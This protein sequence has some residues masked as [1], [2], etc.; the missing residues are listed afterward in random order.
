MKKQWNPPF[1]AH[2]LIVP[3]ITVAKNYGAM[4]G[5]VIAEDVFPTQFIDAGDTVKFGNTTFSVLYT[6]GHAR[7]HLSFYEAER[8][9][10]FSGDVLFDSGV[11]RWDFPGGDFDILMQSIFNELLTLP[12]ETTVYCGHGNE[13]TIGREKRL[14]PYVKSYL[15][16]N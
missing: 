5:F 12:E 16:Q 1:L 2:E 10:V 4:Y 6:P 3:E 9:S 15:K 8:K 14:N 7:S 13:T 11:G